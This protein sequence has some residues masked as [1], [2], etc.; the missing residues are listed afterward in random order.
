VPP[1]R[2]L[3]GS[4]PE[5]IAWSCAQR[6]PALAGTPNSVRS[7]RV[8]SAQSRAG[9][10]LL[11]FGGPPAGTSVGAGVGGL[12]RGRRLSRPRRG[13]TPRG[14]AKLRGARADRGGV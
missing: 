1:V 7:H 2:E 13:H 4:G 14:A 12:L 11:Q 8:G 6:A 5:A 9:A 10:H 3:G